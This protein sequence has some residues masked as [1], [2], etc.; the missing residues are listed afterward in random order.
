MS[1]SDLFTPEEEQRYKELAEQASYHLQE[2]SKCDHRLFPYYDWKNMVKATGLRGPNPYTPEEE[3]EMK[4]VAK[5]AEYHMREW[6]KRDR[7]VRH[8]R[9]MKNVIACARQEGLEQARRELQKE[10]ELAALSAKPEK[11]QSQP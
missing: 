10:K 5:Q 1:I 6:A 4:E 8:Y 9:D 2:L 3:E 7:E 11:N